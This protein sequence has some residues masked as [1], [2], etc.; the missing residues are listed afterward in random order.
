MPADGRADFLGTHKDGHQIIERSAFSRHLKKWR[1]FFIP[2]GTVVSGTRW[3]WMRQRQ[4]IAMS[5]SW[6]RRIHDP[7]ANAVCKRHF[8]FPNRNFTKLKEAHDH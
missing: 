8:Y 1:T 4:T 2:L 3:T 6:W 7:T 5:A